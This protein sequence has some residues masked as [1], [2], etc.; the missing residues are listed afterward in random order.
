MILLTGRCG[1]I[2]SN[3]VES[4]NRQG[5]VDIILADRL[6]HTGKWLNIANK[7]IADY[8]DKD[9]L[10]QQIDEENIEAVIHL[11]ARTDT[12][13]QDVKLILE[14][15]YEYSKALWRYCAERHIRFIYASSAAVYGDGNRGFAEDTDPD[16]LQPLNPYAYSKLLFDRWVFRQ[17]KAPSCWAGLRFFNVYGPGELHKGRMASMVFQAYHQSVKDGSIRL[18][19]SQRA[20]YGHGEQQ[21]DFI[22]V[23]DAADVV[24]FFYNSAS[25]TP[26]IYNVGSGQSRTFN[27]LAAAVL[28][29]QGKAAPIEYV[30]M[31]AHLKASYQYYTRADLTK[32]RRAGYVQ[33]FKD[34]EHGVREYVLYLEANKSRFS[35]NM[36]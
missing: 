26:G 12:T 11:G 36:R 27:E 9:K 15:N 29:A 32:L 25:F 31:A 4:L 17:K 22:Y 16:C 5:T 10:F 24:M 2:G 35:E 14:D 30:E 34:L 13:E 19:K 1:L 33:N 28:A 3:V 23:K 20:D 18:F 21:R 8:V 7:V 6:D